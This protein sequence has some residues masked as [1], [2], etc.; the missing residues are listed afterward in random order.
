MVHKGFDIMKD[1]KWLL[2]ASLI[3]VMLI[4]VGIWCT[5]FDLPPSVGVSLDPYSGVLVVQTAMGQGSCFV[6]AEQDD[7]IYAITA[8]HVV[9]QTYL[10]DP[11][12]AVLTVDDEQYEAEVRQ[13][14]ID[15]D[16]ALIRFQSPET[17]RVYTIGT[18]KVGEACTAVGWSRGSLLVYKGYIVSLDFE[19][20]VVANGGVVPGCSGGPLLNAEGQIIGVT[21]EVAIYRGW[22]FDNT[23]LYTPVRFAQALIIMIGEK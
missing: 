8:F 21:I 12:M 2:P 14:D 19:G 13:I 4:G 20:R 6:V 5:T 11:N 15:Q 18:A 22:A 23:A 1:S 16:V 10:P 17:Y 7:W 3:C 9:A